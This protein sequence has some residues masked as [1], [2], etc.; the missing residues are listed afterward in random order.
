MLHR[1][2][3]YCAL[4]QCAQDSMSSAH[5]WCICMV[6]WYT[7]LSVCWETGISSTCNVLKCAIHCLEAIHLHRRLDHCRT[8]LIG[9]PHATQMVQFGFPARAASHPLSPKCPQGD[10]SRFYIPGWNLSLCRKPPLIF[11]CISQ[12]MIR[13]II[14][15]ALT[16][17]FWVNF[18][19]VAK[20]KKSFPHV[21]GFH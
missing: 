8:D 21:T 6:V 14:L 7:Y 3:S 12:A 9:F 19:S 20:Q 15:L 17:R 11:I 16:F 2:I 4:V 1:T 10:L 5:F 13:L 18:A